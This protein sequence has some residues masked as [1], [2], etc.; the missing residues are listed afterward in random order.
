M[1]PKSEQRSAN[2]G[3]SPK[4][5]RIFAESAVQIRDMLSPE[6]RAQLR[7]GPRSAFGRRTPVSERRR[8]E[9]AAEI[10]EVVSNVLRARGL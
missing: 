8:E 9:V 3:S 1:R 5:T 10:R 6:E 2:P 4:V 7:A